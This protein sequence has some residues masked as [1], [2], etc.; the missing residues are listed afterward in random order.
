MKLSENFALSEFTKSNTAKRH[1][2]DNTPT[3][4]HTWNLKRL[5]KFVLQPLRNALG[6]VIII[7]S[8]YRGPMLNAKIGGSKTSDHCNGKAGDIEEANGDNA[9]LFHYIKDNLDFD[10]LIWEFGDDDQPDWVHASYRSLSLNR[11][12]VLVSYKENGRTKYKNY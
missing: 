5:C 7:S 2:I 1:G 8:G 6:V 4:V 9:S 3:E 11:K 10:Q 12:Q